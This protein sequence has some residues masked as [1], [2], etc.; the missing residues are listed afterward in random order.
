[1]YIVTLPLFLVLGVC[2]HTVFSF[3]AL[4]VF[5]FPLKFFSFCSLVPAPLFLPLKS[6]ILWGQKFCCGHSHCAMGTGTRQ[7]HTLSA[8]APAHAMGSVHRT[9]GKI[10]PRNLYLP[11]LCALPPAEDPT[12]Q[13]VLLPFFNCFLVISALCRSW[14][15]A[16]PNPVMLLTHVNTSEMFS[17]SLFC[18]KQCSGRRCCSPKLRLTQTENTKRCEKLESSTEMVIANWICDFPGARTAENAVIE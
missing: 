6:S 8:L 12:H 16:H 7:C 18:E 3:W 5:Y 2:L 17:L 14:P 1:M 10:Y 4:S 15:S 11:A 9:Q 13:D